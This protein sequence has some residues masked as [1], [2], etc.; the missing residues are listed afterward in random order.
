[1]SC[2]RWCKC[3]GKPQFIEI[4][5]L[6]F[7]ERMI[8]PLQRSIGLEIELNPVGELRDAEKLPLF[9]KYQ[10]VRDGSLRNGGQ[11]M[12]VSP[13]QGDL[14][15][16]GIISLGRMFTFCGSN[17]DQYCG[18]HVHIGA[19]DFDPFQLRRL[20]LLY[21]KVEGEIFKYLIAPG[22]D[23]PHSEGGYCESYKMS[24]AW[25]EG[26]RKCKSSSEI[27]K[28]LIHWLYGAGIKMWSQMGGRN[29]KKI[30]NGKYVPIPTF[31][32][33][34]GN[35]P[36]LRAHKYEQCRYHGLNIHSWFQRGTVEFRQHE[37]TVDVEKLLYW[38]LFCVNLVEVASLLK[39]EEVGRIST[40]DEVVFGEWKKP[41]QLLTFPSALK[42]WYK[43]MKQKKEG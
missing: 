2:R 31:H 10:L 24:P 20:I 25:Y 7:R 35:L 9:V 15:V 32:D 14:F 16:K 22:R 8:N 33:E 39:D 4:P 43:G 19:T 37:G 5:S 13:L 29:G 1:M 28:Y 36:N 40:L 6:P 41:L 26:L 23:I 18:F 21:S 27:K 12:V 38:P 42:E 34:I 17:V 30:K 3:G 11:E